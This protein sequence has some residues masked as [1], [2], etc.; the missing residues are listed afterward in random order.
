MPKAKGIK[1]VRKI[2]S[3]FILTEVNESSL[4]ERERERERACGFV[5]GS[6]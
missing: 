4:R 1:L 5:I 2:G 6:S 3:G